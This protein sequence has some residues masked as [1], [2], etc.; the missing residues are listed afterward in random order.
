MG[1]RTLLLL[2]AVAVFWMPDPGPAT[3]EA[4]PPPKPAVPES[5]FFQYPLPKWEPHCL[6][7]GSEWR[8]CDG[9]VLRACPSGAIWRH[10]GVDIKTG[11][12]PVMAA[13]DG[14]IAGY[15]VD[16]TFRGG[17]LIRHPT[18]EG[19]VL[20]QYWHVWPRPGFGVGKS[21]SRGEVFADVAD[22]GARTHLHFAVF[23]GDFV[24]D[25]W[26]GA[27]PPTPCSGF[28]AFPNRF[29][30]PNGFIQAHLEPPQVRG[31]RCR[32][33]PDDL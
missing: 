1:L 10:T 8:Y 13:A 11:L 4:Q 2:G 21:V 15:I 24:P 22:M 23:Q 31:R 9:T 27:L 32:L 17:M 25:A 16:P 19:V 18:S 7:F 14:V 6:G 5:D 20:T 28:P 30:E 26:R 29:I 33:G 3:A 12:Q